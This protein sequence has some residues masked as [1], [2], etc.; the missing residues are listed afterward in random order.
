VTEHVAQPPAERA[1]EL[2]ATFGT[3]P[4]RVVAHIAR[5]DHPSERD[6]RLCCVVGSADTL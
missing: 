1:A 6:D 4:G 5:A 2:I 3:E